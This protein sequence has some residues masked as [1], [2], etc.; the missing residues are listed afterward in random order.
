M[1]L[2]CRLTGVR[3]SRKNRGAKD[4]AKRPRI[5]LRNLAKN[6][7]RLVRMLF[8]IRPIFWIYELLDSSSERIEMR[9]G[10]DA[11]NDQIVFDSQVSR[12][13]RLTHQ[14]GG[15]CFT[16]KLWS[17]PCSPRYWGIATTGELTEASGSLLKV[18][19]KDWITG[20]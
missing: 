14:S 1:L 13:S 15:W 4:Q 9:A 2:A 11:S 18:C 17:D 8:L 3:L 12:P 6:F 10:I 7:T 20:A 19:P 16:V 5:I